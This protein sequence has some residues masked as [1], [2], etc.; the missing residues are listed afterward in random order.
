MTEPCQKR[1]HRRLA[2]APGPDQDDL[3]AAPRLP[4]QNSFKQTAPRR[5][6][7]TCSRP[8]CELRRGLPYEHVQPAKS[9]AARL[10][11]LTQKPC[12]QGAIDKVEHQSPIL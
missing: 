7:G 6:I 11:G 5:H 1:A 4:N 12:L 8:E 9:G 2:A 10:G 3:W